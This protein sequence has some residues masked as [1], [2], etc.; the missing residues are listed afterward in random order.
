MYEL[1]EKE[2]GLRIPLPWPYLP[3][4]QLTVFVAGV[5]KLPESWL[6]RS[7][8][9]CEQ[10]FSPSHLPLL[11]DIPGDACICSLATLTYYFVTQTPRCLFSACFHEQHDVPGRLLRKCNSEP[12]SATA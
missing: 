3:Q 1:C 5:T 4:Q 10:A 11:L 8:L 9:R 6:C 2:N 12:N 7:W